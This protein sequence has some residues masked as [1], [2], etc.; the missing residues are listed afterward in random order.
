MLVAFVMF[1]RFCSLCRL[2]CVWVGGAILAWLWAW[3]QKTKNNEIICWTM[4]KNISLVSNFFS[5]THCFQRLPPLL[6]Y[7]AQTCTTVYSNL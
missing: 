2:G 4:K 1:F 5:N 7:L 3:K 6:P